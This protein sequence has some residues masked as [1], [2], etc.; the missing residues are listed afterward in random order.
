M[1]RI[2]HRTKVSVIL[3]LALMF[4]VLCSCTP[5]TST[6]SHFESVPRQVWHHDLP[7]RFEPIWNDST[8]SHELWV[9][10][11]HT[12]IYP[13]GTLPMVV[14]LIGDSGQVIRHR[15]S[16]SVTDGAGNWQG[17]G[18][19]TLF[20]CQVHVASGVTASHARHVV[21]WQA[22]DSCDALPGVSDVGILLN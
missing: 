12:Q 18:F 5:D 14:D 3:W 20:Q 10:V 4:A 13:F 16:L 7:I 8:S 21:V 9:T 11:R 6:Y 1:T 19:G 2:T 17:Q 22:V 15:V